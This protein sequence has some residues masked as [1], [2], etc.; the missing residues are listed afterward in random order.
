M[1]ARRPPLAARLA[2]QAVL[3]AEETPLSAGLEQ[4]RRLYEL[5]MA[6]EDR[7]E[8]MTRVPREAPAGVPRPVTRAALG[9]VGRRHDGRRHRAAGLRG[10]ACARCCTT[11]CRRRSSAARERVRAG[12]RSA[13]WRTAARRRTRPTL[14][15]TGR[16]ASR[17]SRRCEL[18][19]EAAP[20]RLELKRELFERLSEIVR[21]TTRCSPPTPRSIPVTS[22]AGAAAR[23]ENV[24]GM[25][26][27]NPPPLMQ[28]LEVIARR[29]DRRA[30]AGDRRARPA[31]RWAS[32]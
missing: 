27:F 23:P 16:R 15:E 11:R 19:I 29:P 24:V 30:G 10:R 1:V 2:K 21:P 28:L 20:E 32:A 6:T 8:G 4:E 9:V 25:H 7:V 5:A 26:F 17:T 12:P 14:L 13:G 18:V 31:R 22:L 3:A